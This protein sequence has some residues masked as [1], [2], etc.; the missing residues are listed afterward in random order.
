[1]SLNHLF[2][3]C[4]LAVLLA[5]NTVLANTMET[6]VV[7]E[8]MK[9]SSSTLD[10]IKSVIYDNYLGGQ[11]S[12]DAELITSAFNMDSVML[13]P[14]TD[15]QGTPR[16]TRW[17]DMHTEAGSWGRVANRRLDLSKITT[18]STDVI[19]DRL[20]VVSLKVDDSVYEVLSLVKVD[21]VWKIASKVY[22]PQ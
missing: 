2:N 17:L 8:I 3:S 18:L 21:N 1:M 22:I 12:G 14:Y 6:P 9:S 5:G 20:A 13:R 7:P 11:K 10:S 16:L 19:D 4:A 15:E